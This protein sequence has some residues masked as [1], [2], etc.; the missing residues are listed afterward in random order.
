MLHCPLTMIVTIS[1]GLQVTIPATIREHLGLDMGSKVEI[2][3]KE[4]A[5]LLRPL[6][7]DLEKIFQ[8]AKR[9]KPKHHFTP[10]K[11]DELNERIF[12]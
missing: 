7:E 6:G 4:G 3:E 9:I 12:Q 2:E 8:R 10:A 5:I 1:R 11:M